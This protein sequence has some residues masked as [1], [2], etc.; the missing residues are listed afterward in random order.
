ML[1]NPDTESNAK[2]LVLKSAKQN[3]KSTTMSNK[4]LVLPE[5]HQMKYKDVWYNWFV[6]DPVEHRLFGK[7]HYAWGVPQNTSGGKWNTI[8][9]RLCG[10]FNYQTREIS[11]LQELINHNS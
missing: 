2:S 8:N 7:K 3:P 6:G 4:L 5:N 9:A 11:E 10:I 1:V